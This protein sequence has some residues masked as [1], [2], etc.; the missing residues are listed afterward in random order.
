MYHES[1]NDTQESVSKRIHVTLPDGVYQ[2]L[3][4]WAESEARPVANL[5]SYLLQKVLEEAEEQ[6]K[7]PPPQKQQ[8]R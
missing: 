5:A 4:G 1:Y 3:E 6:G 7:I 8:G 2:K